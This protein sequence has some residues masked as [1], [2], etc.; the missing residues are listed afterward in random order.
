MPMVS[1]LAT[2]PRSPA[3]SEKGYSIARSRIWFS[4]R[5]SLQVV[6]P[7]DSQ[8]PSDKATSGRH[9]RVLPSSPPRCRIIAE[10]VQLVQPFRNALHGSLP[11][12]KSGLGSQGMRRRPY[13]LQDDAH[14]RRVSPTAVTRLARGRSAVKRPQNRS[15]AGIEFPSRRRRT[16][17]I[18]RD[19][20]RAGPTHRRTFCEVRLLTID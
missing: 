6:R 2:R 10:P 8:R 11:P 18:L 13:T 16:G 20:R 4:F 7:R 15:S 17:L 12:P 19:L 9:G 14:R 1:A 5:G 3:S